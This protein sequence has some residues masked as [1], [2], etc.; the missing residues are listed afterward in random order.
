MSD[1]TIVKKEFP[2]L[3]A[4]WNERLRCLSEGKL[5]IS[6][7]A[8]LDKERFTAPRNCK[9]EVW[10]ASMQAFY[11]SESIR[12]QANDFFYDADDVWRD[13]VVQHKG[14]IRADWTEVPNGGGWK[15]KLETGEEFEP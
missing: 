12:R 7:A 3:A 6:R 5:Y 8:N 9:I 4:A 1:K 14:N 10:F 11:E 13:A 2:T 15:C